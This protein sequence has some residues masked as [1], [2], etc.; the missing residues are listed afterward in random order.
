MK[1][2][3]GVSHKQHLA[4]LLRPSRLIYVIL[5]TV[6]GYCGQA[7]LEGGGG[8]AGGGELSGAVGKGFLAGLVAPAPSPHPKLQFT[9]LTSADKGTAVH[10]PEGDD[11]V[12]VG[13][14]RCDVSVRLRVGLDPIVCC[15]LRRQHL[16]HLWATTRM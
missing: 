3:P 16:T 4:G 1:G 9:I 2:R 15:A 11:G 10:I 6:L 12:Q 13:L 5:G 8:S 14:S 7:L